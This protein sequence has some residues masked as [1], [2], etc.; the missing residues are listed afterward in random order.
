MAKRLS[1][2]DRLRDEI[3]KEARKVRDETSGLIRKMSRGA[4][5]LDLP[6]EEIDFKLCWYN[7]QESGEHLRTIESRLA[8]L[9][10]LRDDKRGH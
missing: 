1:V 6:L 8:R 5:S 3:A 7:V 2:E 10:G 4:S 9:N